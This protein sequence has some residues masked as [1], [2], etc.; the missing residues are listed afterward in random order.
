MQPLRVSDLWPLPVYEGVRDQFRK[1]VIAA[2][3][4]R[5]LEVGPH[6]TLV[7]ENRLTVK[8]Q[9]Q[10]I[11]RAER[12]TAPEHVQ[13][14]LEGFNGMLP[15]E[16]ELSATLLI[17]FTGSE[18]EV[19]ARLAALS[20]L[21]EAVFLEL[22][23]RRVRAAFEAGRDDGRRVSAV[24]YLRFPVG[25]AAG[26]LDASQRARLSVEHPAY[27][28]A[29]ELTPGMRRSLAQDLGGAP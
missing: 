2:K 26:L 17:A 9:V 12:I 5:R 19:A 10:E 22:G 20:G 27:R 28:H 13:E 7:F 23:G 8:F 1:E 16:G 11:L 14:E 25:S 4:D 6:M 29:A 24:Q 18:S 21:G 15:G 3:V